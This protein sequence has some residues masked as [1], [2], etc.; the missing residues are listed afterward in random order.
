[1]AL[2][3]ADAEQPVEQSKQLNRWHL[4]A[5]AISGIIGSGWLLA[6]PKINKD[7]SLWLAIVSWLVGAALMGLLAVVVIQLATA[8]PVSGGFVRWPTESTGRGVGTIIAAGLIVVYSGNPPIAAVAV[9]QALDGNF[10]IS[11]Y[12]LVA[13]QNND[14]GVFLTDSGLGIA[15]V[16]LTILFVINLFGLKLVARVNSAIT[17]IKVA[18]PILLAIGLLTLFVGANG[19]G[20]QPL[21]SQPC[22]PSAEPVSPFPLVNGLVTAGILFA[23]TGFQGPVD[24]AG[25]AD[26]KQIRF[27]VLGALALTACIYVVLQVGYHMADI[28]GWGIANQFGSLVGQWLIGLLL[29]TMVFS[30]LATALVFVSFTGASLKAASDERLVIAPFF[31]LRTVLRDA[32]YGALV[33]GYLTGLALLIFFRGWAEIATAKTVIFLFIYS[34]AAIAYTAFRERASPSE[35]ETKYSASLRILGPL[36]V[37]VATTLAFFSGFDKLAP[38]YVFFLVLAFLMV[39][40]RWNSFDPN[41][42]KHHLPRAWWLLG[43]FLVLLA[44]SGVIKFLFSETWSKDPYISGGL[45]LLAF[46]LGIAAYYVGVR[47]SLKYLDYVEE[48]DRKSDPT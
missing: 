30:P 34:Y 36:S 24:H 7:H 32:P 38:S 48:Q 33:W 43:Y 11:P 20:D 39:A 2:K 6:I 29:V 9:V 46:A 31:D 19:D 10:G 45:G 14:K 22:D 5:L 21:F 4:L 12:S 28:E 27:A 44:L 25:R 18:V 37:A 35:R 16:V 42:F 41:F 3:S 23:F 1:M 17:V 13:C 40:S 26:R 47:E 8:R 15:G